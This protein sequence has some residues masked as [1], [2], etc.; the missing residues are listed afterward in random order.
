MSGMAWA[1]VPSWSCFGGTVRG[2]L[3]L[4]EQDVDPRS[5]GEAAERAAQQPGPSPCCLLGSG[6]AQGV[7]LRAALRVQG[8]PD[9][10]PDRHKPPPTN[11][12][13]P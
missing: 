8:E 2:V 6:P 1:A 10:L 13:S 9:G 12:F 5:V 4:P 7:V 11:A 3:V